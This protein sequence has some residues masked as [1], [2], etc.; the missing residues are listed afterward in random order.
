MAAKQ[1]PELTLERRC[2]LE[3]IPDSSPWW[4]RSLSYASEEGDKPETPSM[5]S[6][7]SSFSGKS[8]GRSGKARGTSASLLVRESSMNTFQMR[9]DE[10][11]WWLSR[12]NRSRPVTRLR[13]L[14]KKYSRREHALCCMEKQHPLRR[15][16]RRLVKCKYPAASCLFV[17][18]SVCLSVCQH[19][20]V[21]FS[22]YHTYISWSIHFYEGM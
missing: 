1:R 21:H 6:S 19:L 22:V 13:Q 15:R 5:P 9:E 12:V 7:R 10:E 4:R 3:E 8:V 17:R 11:D 20:L 16:V 18:L 2:S 14:V